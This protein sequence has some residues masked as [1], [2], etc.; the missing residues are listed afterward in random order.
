MA[1]SLSFR[2]AGPG[3]L[4][5]GFRYPHEEQACAG[6]PVAL[7]QSQLLPTQ[8]QAGFASLSVGDY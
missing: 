6:S 1:Y 3:I 2:S 5:G 7:A 4:S 8:F